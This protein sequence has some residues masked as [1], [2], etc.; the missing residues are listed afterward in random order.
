MATFEDLNS[1]VTLHKRTFKMSFTTMLGSSFL[2]QYYRIFLN[3]FFYFFV[4]KKGNNIVGFIVGVNDYR[5]LSRCLKRNMHLFVIPIMRSALNLKLIPFIWKR[6]LG[7]IFNDRVNTVPFQLTDH[8]EITSFAVDN[9]NQGLGI[10]SNL[11]KRYSSQA[12]NDKALGVFITTDATN[13]TPTINFYKKNG[14]YIKHT[15]HQ[16]KERKMHLM[17]KECV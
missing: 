12:C 13:N 1:V 17:L 2:F 5:I 15:Y 4:A 9:N 14:F 6:F 16:S 7:F 11:L 10:G 3:D 8:N